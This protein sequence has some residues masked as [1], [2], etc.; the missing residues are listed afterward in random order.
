MIV[1]Y[2]NCIEYARWMQELIQS[3]KL[4]KNKR[5]IFIVKYI[6]D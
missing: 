6:L 5:Y 4:I 1:K 3:N 2:A